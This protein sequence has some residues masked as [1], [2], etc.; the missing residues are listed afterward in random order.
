MG[1]MSVASAT[2]SRSST[3]TSRPAA[4]RMPL[5][6]SL[7]RAGQRA[8]LRGSTRATF[9]LAR[10]LRS[11]QA[12]PIV[13][14]DHQ[15][16]FVDL[17]NGLTH[18]LLEG[19]PWQSVP[20][21]AQEQIVM[22][23]V[24]RPGDVVLDIGANIGLHVALLADLVGPRGHV[25]A[26]EPQRELIYALQRTAQHAGNVSVHPFG[27]GEQAE[28]RTFYIPEGDLSM[29]SF[30]DWTEGR[31][32]EVHSDT[33]DLRVLDDLV[34][35]GTVAHPRFIK[36]DVE[37]A[38]TLVFR[39]ARETLNVP[40]AAMVLYEADRGSAKAFGL[41]LDAASTVLRDM[42]RARFHIFHVR[43]NGLLNPLDRFLQDC[44]YYNLLAVPEARLGEIRPL[45]SQT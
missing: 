45:T 31:V 14:N 42:P 12:V 24:V 20:W 17:R 18:L 27:L 13:V 41:P 26:F 1:T 5:L 36:C 35:E 43:K 40:D 22:R 21:E 4:P 15:T 37:G 33:C 9:T 10:W 34:R 7:L 28:R 29:A 19:S 38:E 11:L 2:T 32:G 44:D 16:M 30:A 39:G 3:A 6:A 8:R 25:H 23:Q